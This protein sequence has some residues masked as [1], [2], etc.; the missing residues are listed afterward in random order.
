ML[1]RASHNP[2]AYEHRCAAPPIAGSE[3]PFAARA[4][5]RCL[6][7]RT[8]ADCRLLACSSE[9]LGA[10]LARVTLGHTP[11]GTPHCVP[12]RSPAYPNASCP[13]CWSPATRKKKSEPSR[14]ERSCCRPASRSWRTI[15][16]YRSTA[17][18]KCGLPTM[19]QDSRTSAPCSDA[20]SGLGPAQRLAVRRGENAE[21]REHGL[22]VTRR[23]MHRDD[24]RAC[25]T[26]NW[27]RL[28][29]RPLTDVAPGSQ[30]G[31]Q[32]DE[33]EPRQPL[34]AP[35]RRSWRRG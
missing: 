34:E 24:V 13:S 26:G 8:R 10:G 31:G 21:D 35:G 18:G 28:E 17:A 4:R 22:K 15:A 11:S 30:C 27:D 29:M 14:A 23:L 5:N 9:H 6:Q 16:R 3:A 32:H 2:R 20:C 25:L 1:V 12:M 19:I 7:S 33:G